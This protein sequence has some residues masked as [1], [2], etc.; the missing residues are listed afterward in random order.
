MRHKGVNEAYDVFN[1][2]EGT[3]KERVKFCQAVLY[4]FRQV[5]DDGKPIVFDDEL[6]TNEKTVVEGLEKDANIEKAP[7]KEVNN[8]IKNTKSIEADMTNTK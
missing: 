7:N 1:L 8:T 5:E 3:G 6:T 2:D 4:A